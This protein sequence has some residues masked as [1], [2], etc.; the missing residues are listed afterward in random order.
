METILIHLRNGVLE[1]VYSGSSVQY[2]LIDTDEDSGT[3]VFPVNDSFPLPGLAEA[4]PDFNKIID[5]LIGEETI[6]YTLPNVYA[7]YLMNGDSTGLTND[8]QLEIDSFVNAHHIR[9]IEVKEN[10]EFK[11]RNDLNNLGGDCSTFVFTTTI[12]N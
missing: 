6:N 5:G 3:E 10:S 4:E 8:E 2:I 12:K 9:L 1:S 11:H 7:G